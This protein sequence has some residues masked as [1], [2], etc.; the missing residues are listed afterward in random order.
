MQSP[1]QRR[2]QVSAAVTQ[3]HTI[4][5]RI[6]AV[7]LTCFL[8]VCLQLPVSE[9]RPERLHRLVCWKCLTL[10]VFMREW[11]YAQVCVFACE[12][13][14]ALLPRWRPCDNPDQSGVPQSSLC[15]P[16]PSRW[17]TSC[18]FCSYNVTVHRQRIL[19]RLEGVFCFQ[20]TSE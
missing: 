15:L 3:G 14:V 7:T 16:S 20:R 11:T 2:H 1:N 8:S 5:I 17:C 4:H 12:R 10:S 9:V 18:N 19:Q 13:H 6:P